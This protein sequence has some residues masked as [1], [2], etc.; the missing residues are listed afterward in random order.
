MKWVYERYYEDEQ[1]NLWEEITTV[2]RLGAAGFYNGKVKAFRCRTCNL[3]TR[4]TDKLCDAC[5]EVECKLES[6][7]RSASARKHVTSLLKVYI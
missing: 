2:Q 1:G 6:Y 3:P 4:N 7:L 5:W